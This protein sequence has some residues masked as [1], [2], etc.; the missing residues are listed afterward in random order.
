MKS[1]PLIEEKDAAGNNICRGVSILYS[2][3]K[4]ENSYHIQVLIWIVL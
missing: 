3:A 1:M 2:K 4:Q